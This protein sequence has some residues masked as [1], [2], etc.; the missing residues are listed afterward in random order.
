M[1]R[2]R[3]RATRLSGGG[4]EEGGSTRSLF[5]VGVSTSSADVT[6]SQKAS[7]HHFDWLDVSH[8]YTVSLCVATDLVCCISTTPTANNFSI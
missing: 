2:R 6:A 1:S 7:P 3:S 4:D 5:S 8:H